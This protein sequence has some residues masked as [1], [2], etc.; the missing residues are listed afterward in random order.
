MDCLLFTQQKCCL[1]ARFLLRSRRISLL[2]KKKKY[3]SATSSPTT[4]TTFCAFVS[5]LN[6]VFF[7][8]SCF[9]CCCSVEQV[10]MPNSLEYQPVECAIVVNAAGAF[11]GNLARMLGVGL[12]PRDSIAGIPLPV[13]PRKRSS[14]EKHCQSVWFCLGALRGGTAMR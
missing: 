1:T 13:E 4:L 10:Q 12:G 7:L 5:I 6:A 14:V 9:S 8:C 2:L 11:S 3:L